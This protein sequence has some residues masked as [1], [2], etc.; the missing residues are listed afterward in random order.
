MKEKL[1]CIL[2]FKNGNLESI[3]NALN[4]L[5]I[6]N[7]VSNKNNDIDKS[8]H[9]ILPGV[10]AYNHVMERVNTFLMYSF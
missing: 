3:V 7:I 8:S 10:G 6:P 5:K 9:L 4:F 2:D 1:V